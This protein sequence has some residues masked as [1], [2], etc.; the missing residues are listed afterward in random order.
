MAPF[1]YTCF[2][3][4]VPR[5]PRFT[6]PAV[7]PMPTTTEVVMVEPVE[8]DDVDLLSPVDAMRARH[9]AEDRLPRSRWVAYRTI[10]EG[11]GIVDHDSAAQDAAFVEWHKDGRKASRKLAP[12]AG[13]FLDAFDGGDKRGRRSLSCLFEG[14][15]M[16]TRGMETWREVQAVMG[17]MRDV[18]GLDGL[19]LPTEILTRHA[20]QDEEIR[21]FDKAE[22]DDIM[23]MW[24][25]A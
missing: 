14:F 3:G 5:E 24:D 1:I 16:V 12:M 7:L 2:V 21:A 23:A 13:S 20:L 18:P 25:I 22:E 15:M 17:I 8:C 19:A 9:V 11:S 10:L 6:A 4:D